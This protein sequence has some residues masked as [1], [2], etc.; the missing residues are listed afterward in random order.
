MIKYTPEH[1]V[2]IRVL[3]T[4]NLVINRTY[5]QRLR[6]Q[7]RKARHTEIQ[8]KFNLNYCQELVL[9]WDGT[10]LPTLTGVE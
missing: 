10:L 9:H 1:N 2:A 4:K 7:F 6:K 8:N 5:L 3:D